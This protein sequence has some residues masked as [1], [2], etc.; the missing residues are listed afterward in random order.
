MPEPYEVTAARKITGLE[1]SFRDMNTRESG[2]TMGD[3]IGSILG[4]P[5]LR[6]FWPMSSVN[7]SGN[8][9]DI[10]GQ[11]RTLTNNNAAARAVH[12]DLIPYVS[13][14]GT[15]QYLSRADEAGLDITGALTIG[16]WIY[17]N[18]A[19]G[20]SIEWG[21]NKT[22]ASGN[23]GYG[24]RR[25]ATTGL[26]DFYISSTG[27]N[28]PGAA[29][30]DALAAG[31]WYFL[32]GRFTPSTEIAVFTN[33][34][35]FVNTTSIPAAI[36]NSSAALAIGGSNGAAGLAGRASLGFV[37]AAALPDAQINYFFHMSR[38]LFGV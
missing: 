38:T 13:F 33:K 9:L 15:T 14:N 10:S 21:I 7:E 30:T 18:N 27:S 4:F 25:L 23:F 17:F 16:Q 12:R 24:V 5:E 22:G 8:V 3:L 2:Y 35:K 26:P 31:T 19:A 36:F 20:A 29:G 32:A 11:A 37:C 28:Y 34:D 1:S 6:A